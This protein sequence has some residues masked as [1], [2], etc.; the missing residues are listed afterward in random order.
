MKQGG[1][2]YLSVDE[3]IDIKLKKENKA[4]KK[5]KYEHSYPHCWRTDK[6]ILYYP[7]DSWF[8]KTTAIKDRMVELN[9]AINWKPEHTGT[10]RF[11]E[12]L[13]NLQ[14]WNLSR[15]RFWGI[16]LPVWRTEDGEEE[17]VIGSVED[18]K[19]EIEKA[20]KAG[21]NSDFITEEGKFD[22]HKPYIDRVIL[23][24]DSGKKMV[25][26]SDLIDVWFDSG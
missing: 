2:K 21:F 18:L 17:K 13:N 24:T 23:V 15:S 12:W 14:D 26:E 11:G 7:L 19:N 6:P 10:G 3:R 9:K 16:P 1:D 25:R 22:L 20:K 4:F 5:E 8:V